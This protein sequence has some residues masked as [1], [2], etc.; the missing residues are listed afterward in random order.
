MSERSVSGTTCLVLAT[1]FFTV[2]VLLLGGCGA[3]A[4]I[5]GV[6]Q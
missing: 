2:P 1:V 3:L 5:A 6:F 4:L